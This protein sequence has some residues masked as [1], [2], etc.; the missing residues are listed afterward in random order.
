MVH[1]TKLSVGLVILGVLEDGIQSVRIGR[2]IQGNRVD[3]PVIR[4][5]Y[6]GLPLILGVQ[7]PVP[8]EFVLQT[9]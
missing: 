2:N 6:A 3:V 9:T 4:Q 8:R 5:T 7:Q 1:G